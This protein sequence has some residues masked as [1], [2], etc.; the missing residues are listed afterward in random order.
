MFWAPTAA[1]TAATTT[2]ASQWAGPACSAGNVLLQRGRGERNN[3]RHDVLRQRRHA[4]LLLCWQH[5][6]FRTLHSGPVS[7]EKPRNFSQH[8]HAQFGRPHLR[9][10][11]RAVLDCWPLAS[12]VAFLGRSRRVL[13]LERGQEFILGPELDLNPDAYCRCGYGW[14]R[15]LRGRAVGSSSDVGHFTHFAYTVNFTHYV[16]TKPV[17][18]GF[19]VEITNPAR[20]SCARRM[21]CTVREA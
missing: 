3:K 19:T 18:S 13:S 1:T 7:F 17:C 11:V 12:Q 6:T 10:C 5:T 4:R 8:R 9:H 15:L 21:H 2:R 14:L 16:K 20:V